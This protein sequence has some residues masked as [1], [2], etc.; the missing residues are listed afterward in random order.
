MSPRDP[1]YPVLSS[2]STSGPSVQA[3]GSRPLVIF[4]VVALALLMS[5]LD[6][7]IVATAL[8]ALQHDLSAP[9]T[10]TSWTITAYALGMVIMV[11]IAGK[12]SEQY[13][14]RRIFVGSVVLFTA[15]SL[16][17][18]FADNIYVLVALRFVQALGGAGFTPSATGIIVE[19]FGAVRDKAVGLFGSI[20]SI[21]AMIGPIF[22]GLFITWWSWRGIFFVNVPIGIALVVLSLRFIPCDPKRVHRA[23]KNFDLIGMSALGVGVLA[24]M[25][26]LNA[27]AK[28]VDA[29]L[30]PEFLIPALLALLTL[31]FFV[32]HIR[33]SYHPFIPVA[34]IAG[35]GF[36]AVNLINVV[37]GMI[38]E[39]LVALVPLYAITRYGLSP[40]GAGLLLT[41][42][43]AAIILM[44]GLG[45]L[46]L[47]KS[48]YRLP[49]Y[50]GVGAMA[51]GVAALA[52]VPRG[53][54][55]YAWL[56]GVTCLIG[57]GA[58][59]ISPASRNAGLQLA[60]QHSPTLAALRTMSFQIGA[61]AAISIT[62]AAIAGAAHPGLVHA[63]VYIGWAVLFLLL[64]P[65]THLI[66]EHRGAW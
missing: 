20:F 57:L 17:C 7:T 48:G 24:V 62:A 42:E 28:G 39:G 65:I 30:R 31:G 4:C 9:L 21:G 13:G 1:A 36:G 11:P 5:S 2:V 10:W 33:R 38:E 37:G 66:P 19:H 44:S 16:C 25:L 18:G 64:L 15:A 22:G 35:H 8:H 40:L 50:I 59:L 46:M 3:A 54:S 55:P 26:A 12:L 60:P 14:R 58:G 63:V 49:I 27:L 56:T 34:F 29:L 41:A 51:V 47:R 53:I 61:I 23:S 43:G 32:R 45:V 6:Q 52:F